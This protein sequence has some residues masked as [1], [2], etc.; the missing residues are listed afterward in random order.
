MKAGYVTGP[1]PRAASSRSTTKISGPK[2]YE[3]KD[4]QDQDGK[5]G[6]NDHEREDRRP[7]FS[8]TRLGRSFDDLTVL[9]RCHGSLI[10][11]TARITRQ[12]ATRDF[13]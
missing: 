3:P 12:R 9:L 8:L 13:D 11:L 7:G 5:A 2:E 1:A 4:A 6:G 10:Q